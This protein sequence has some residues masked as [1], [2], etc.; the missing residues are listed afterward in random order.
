MFFSK[1]VNITHFSGYFTLS[2]TLKSPAITGLQG[3][4]APGRN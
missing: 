1:S 3:F 2:K 4:G